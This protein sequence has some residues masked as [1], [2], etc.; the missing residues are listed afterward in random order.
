MCC[1]AN[2]PS[3]G[4]QWR[5]R[6]KRRDHV[7][8]DRHQGV[9]DGTQSGSSART[10]EGVR[11]G[12]LL[13]EQIDSRYFDAFVHATP[14]GMSPRTGECILY[15]KILADLVFDIVYNPRDSELVQH[16]V[17]QEKTV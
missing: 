11:R 3:C 16:A 7:V 2:R 5:R 8:G 12:A 1:W 17:E 13:R 10:G 4:G 9:A 14:L 6:E 15:D